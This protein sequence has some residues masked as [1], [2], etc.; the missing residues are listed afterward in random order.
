MKD[1]VCS[2]FCLKDRFITDDMRKIVCEM[3]ESNSVSLHIRRTD[4][5]TGLN[6][7]IFSALDTAYYK[8][9]IDTLAE[10]QNIDVT[11]GI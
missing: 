11:A 9:A 8:K 1:K 5:L 6:I 3:E 4:Y 7:D 2:D 10:G